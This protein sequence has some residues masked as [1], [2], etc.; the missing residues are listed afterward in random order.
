MNHLILILIL[1][2]VGALTWLGCRSLGAAL[3]NDLQQLENRIMSKISELAGTLQ[4]VTQ[5]VAK[6]G[7]EVAGVKT[8][9]AEVETQLAN[10]DEVP[11]DLQAA[12][13]ALK[14]QVQSVDD[15]IP[16]AVVE[17]PAN[18]EPAATAE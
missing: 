7:S 3:V 4:E 16:D 15:L 11:P 5:H 6:I 13:E 2:S 8:R 14:A 10:L 1:A 9:L 17:P 18:Q 12:V